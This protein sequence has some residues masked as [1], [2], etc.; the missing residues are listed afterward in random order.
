MS[1]YFSLRDYD[2][3]AIAGILRLLAF[4]V[5]EHL[6]LPQDTAEF[7]LYDEDEVVKKAMEVLKHFGS[8]LHALNDLKEILRE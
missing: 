8:V 1:K 3:E 5:D 6:E 4:I 7:E 2:I